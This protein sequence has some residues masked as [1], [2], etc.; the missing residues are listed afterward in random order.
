MYCRVKF[1]CFYVCLNLCLSTKLILIEFTRCSFCV[2][3]IFF[4]LS[5]CFLLFHFCRI[6][7][8]DAA[9]FL[10]LS[11]LFI[12]YVIFNKMNW[13]RTFTAANVAIVV[14]F[15]WI[16]IKHYS[17]WS[18]RKTNNFLLVHRIPLI[19]WFLNQHAIMFRSFQI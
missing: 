5:F 10:S 2:A 13:S 14:Q 15:I 16:S 1:F 9:F 4:L 8:C 6:I 19:D 7:N 12:F 3:L 17:L 11:C 18:I